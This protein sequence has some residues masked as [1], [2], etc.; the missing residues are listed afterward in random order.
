MA[1]ESLL[2]WTPHRSKF[3]LSARPLNVTLEVILGI[4]TSGVA[5]ASD[6][7]HGTT[8]LPT[9]RSPLRKSPRALKAALVAL[10]RTALTLL[11]VAVSI[12]VPEFASVMAVLGATFSFVLCIIG[13]VCAKV[14]LAGGARRCG[15]W[16]ALLLLVSSA[17]AVWGTMCAFE[18]AAPEPLR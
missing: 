16:D 1:P 12:L 4:D 2:R 9:T 13:P 18:S 8:T 3:A 17:M 5:P 15:P 14:A 7:G 11:A 10:E 6:H